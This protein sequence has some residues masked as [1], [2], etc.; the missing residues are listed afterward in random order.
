MPIT[1]ISFRRGTST[2]LGTLIF[3]G[4]IFTAVIP[5]F[6]VMRQAD[7]L[8]EMRKYELAQ[9]DEEK[10]FENLY[11][12]AHANE[13][14]PTDLTVEVENKGDLSAKVVSLW[15]N[16]EF[17][18]LNQLISPMSGMKDLGSFN[19]SRVLDL[20][21]VVM[22]TTDRGK[23][24]VFDIPLTWTI[25]GWKSPIVSIE[26]LIE[27]LHG[28]GEFKIEITGPENRTAMAQKNELR[29]FTFTSPGTYTV[30]IFRGSQLLHTEIE[31]LD[32]QNNPL[33]RVFA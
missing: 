28:S 27:H 16:D 1:D 4:I 13:S 17:F 22:V 12:Y 18:E 6:L 14:F 26:V 33:W 11:V 30:E 23:I 21:Y 5:M 25:Y 32:F 15:V 3:I 29:C 10:A 2:V 8:H 9:L 24:F 20:E 31:T 19:V 7:T